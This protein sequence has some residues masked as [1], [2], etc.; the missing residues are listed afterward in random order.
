MIAK[1]MCSATFTPCR[2]YWVGKFATMYWFM[3]WLPRWLLELGMCF[4][5]FLVPVRPKHVKAA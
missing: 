1:T 2:H 3:S 5:L 4:W